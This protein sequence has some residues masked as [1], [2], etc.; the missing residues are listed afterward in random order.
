MSAAAS[1][2]PTETNEKT[3]VDR[4]LPIS[5]SQ[6]E[7]LHS[8]YESI[9][10][11]DELR[12]MLHGKDVTLQAQKEALT[13]V[14]VE[15]E[16]LR[17]EVASLRD[18]LD[19]EEAKSGAALATEREMHADALDGER[20]KQD[21]LR[22]RIDRLKTN[23]EQHRQN[24]QVAIMN[25]NT[26]RTIPVTNIYNTVI[27]QQ[28][29]QAPRPQAPRPVGIHCC[30]APSRLPPIP[31]RSRTMDRYPFGP[32]GNQPRSRPGSRPSTGSSGR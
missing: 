7:E 16:T 12:E 1:T 5:D 14:A 18:C 32:P 19:R 3:L 29:Q 9:N 13:A 17:K 30:V 10:D 24:A 27:V 8:S 23:S 31:S 20:T 25:A 4:V 6:H 28:Q 15:V 22:Q 26:A 2:L 21:R 11:R